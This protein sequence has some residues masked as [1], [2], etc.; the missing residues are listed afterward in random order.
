LIQAS[1]HTKIY[2]DESK[3]LK[4]ILIIERLRMMIMAMVPTV[5]EP[6]QETGHYPVENIKDR[7]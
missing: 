3:D 2:K 7:T 4:I 5:Q 1:I 6:Q